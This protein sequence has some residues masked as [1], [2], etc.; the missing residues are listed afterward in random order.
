MKFCCSINHMLKRFSFEALMCSTLCKWLDIIY[1]L[2][3]CKI[4]RS[5]Y[6][7][8]LYGHILP[9]CCFYFMVFCGWI[10][11]YCHWWQVKW[12]PFQ[13]CELLSILWFWSGLSKVFINGLKNDRKESE[14]EGCGFKPHRHRK[15]GK[16]KIT[17][18]AVTISTDEII[19]GL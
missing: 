14:F 4:Q 10:W 15:H 11:I 18:S 13:V 7:G 17:K 6:N 1:H 19:T 2:L 9:S 12:E 5:V 16:P 3:D 8:V